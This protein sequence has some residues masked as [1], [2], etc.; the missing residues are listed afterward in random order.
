MV[1]AAQSPRQESAQASTTGTWNRAWSGRGAAKT[2]QLEYT[3]KAKYT[4]KEE[5]T[6][7]P[8]HAHKKTGPKARV[9]GFCP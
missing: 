1:G 9:R 5:G 4:R 6:S 2:K 8:G 3:L 7:G